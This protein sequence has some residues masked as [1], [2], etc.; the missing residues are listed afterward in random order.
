MIITVSH[1]VSMGHR[2]P[3]YQ[4]I[5]NS[6]HGHNVRFEV[7]LNVGETFVDFK[8]VKDEL[9]SI[10]EDFDHALVLHVDDPLAAI[11]KGSFGPQ[12]LVLL[13]VEPTTEAIAAYVYSAIKIGYR[14]TM[15]HSVTVHETDKYSATCTDS[16][17]GVRRVA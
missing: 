7:S 16:V 14:G 10:V 13:N 2:L 8:S 11:I 17:G 5:C 6:L 12:R 9:I 4:G 1:T 3:S 15:I